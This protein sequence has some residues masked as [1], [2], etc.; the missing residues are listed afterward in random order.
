MISILVMTHGELARGFIESSKMIVGETEKLE[1][2]G[3]YPGDNIDEFNEKVITK[4]QQLNDGSGVLIFTDLYGASP[5]KATAYCA[6]KLGPQSYRSIAGVNFPML[7]ESILM[8]DSKDLDTLALHIMSTG[9]EGI[10]E[11]FVEAGAF[12]KE[13]QA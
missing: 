12:Q 3:L 5:F 10:K 1:W 11:L 13:E 6:S 4:I 8:R 7:I 2:L 9:Q